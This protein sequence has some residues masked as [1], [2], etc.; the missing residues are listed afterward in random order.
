MRRG[1]GDNKFR[2]FPHGS[3]SKRPKTRENVTAPSVFLF[4]FPEAMTLLVS[5]KSSAVLRCQYAD[6][7]FFR[8]QLEGTFVLAER[9]SRGKCSRPQLIFASW[10]PKPKW[11]SPASHAL[12][13]EPPPPSPR[14]RANNGSRE[15]VTW[16]IFDSQ[17]RVIWPFILVDR[18]L[19]LLFFWGW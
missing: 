2:F 14:S 16:G 8:R 13:Y 10:L 6:T 15:G 3:S 4:S 9:Q 1:E 5:T 18:N 17:S 12:A 19:K 11:N 7:S